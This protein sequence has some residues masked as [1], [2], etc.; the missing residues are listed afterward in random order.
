ML[1]VIRVKGSLNVKQDIAFTLRILRLNQV[2]HCILLDENPTTK[3]M[4]QKVK[5]CVT[6]GEI[7]RD[8]LVELL[9]KRG[10]LPGGRSIDKKALKEM[11]AKDFDSLA[12]LML[13]GKART[14][15][16]LKPVFRLH[17]PVQG[18]EGTK[19]TYV[20]GG[21]LGYRGQAIN[22]LIRRML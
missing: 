4:L 17:P 12:G 14:G 20:I 11:G 22:D 8:A 7:D 18:Y 9:E 16:I 21:A 3:G 6:W 15:E 19:K 2:N 13:G 5:D 1:A 10:R